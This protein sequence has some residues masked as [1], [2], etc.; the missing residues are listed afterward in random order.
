[1]D[2]WH[3]EPLAEGHDRG[4]FECGEENL[5]VFL[6]QH[7]GQNAHRDI[8]RTYIA[9]PE[10]SNSV[11]GY[12][13]L[14]TGS[15]ARQDLPADAASRLPRYPV[16]IAHLGRLAV[17][18]RV[19]GRGLGK[20]LLADALKLVATLADQIGIHAVTVHA[21]NDRARTFYLAHGFLPLQD[22]P[23]HLYLPMATIRQQM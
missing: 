3:I 2:I 15:V 22:D 4:G 11:V 5:N 23:S 13:T 20:I 1:M 9:L 7:A 21:L 16:P 14:A 10:G 6:R 19:Q 8:S 12:Y 18:R 17:D